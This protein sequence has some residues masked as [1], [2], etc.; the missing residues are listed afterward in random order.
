[1]PL[2]QFRSC[3]GIQILAAHSVACVKQVL[4]N[5][6]ALQLILLHN[7]VSLKFFPEQ[8]V[9]CFPSNVLTF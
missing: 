3:V 9:P 7:S 2:I 8:H 1:M 5:S 4:Q 6:T